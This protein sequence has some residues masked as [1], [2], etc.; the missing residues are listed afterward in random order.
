MSTVNEEHNSY[1][2][3]LEENMKANAALRSLLG[4]L[5]DCESQP[6]SPVI[7]TSVVPLDYVPSDPF[8]S[9]LIK[10][11]LERVGFPGKHKN[12]YCVVPSITKPVTKKEVVS[13]GYGR[14]V[15]EKVLGKGSFGSVFKAF[16]V[17]ENRTVALK[18]QKPANKWEF[19]ICREI[20]ARLS[21]HPLKKCFMDIH[22]GY[23]SK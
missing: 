14:Y 13:I 8:K 6:S 17:C 4:E 22:V 21:K 12:G 18:Y 20:Q 16:D 10:R 9:E 7:E 2:Y 5:M 15:V 23:Y 1:H 11:L 3:N 19:Y